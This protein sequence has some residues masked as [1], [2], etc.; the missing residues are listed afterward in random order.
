MFCASAQLQSAQGRSDTGHFINPIFAGD[1]ADP[2]ILRDGNT[3][4]MVHSSF[5]YYPGLLIWKSNDLMS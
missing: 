2:S 4:Y 1:Y 5:E 3:Y